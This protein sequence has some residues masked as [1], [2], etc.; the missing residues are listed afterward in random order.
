[1]VFLLVV[2]RAIELW[3]ARIC[4]DKLINGSG[5]GVFSV[6]FLF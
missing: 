3:S 2:L 5:Y 4:V 1:M 6:F